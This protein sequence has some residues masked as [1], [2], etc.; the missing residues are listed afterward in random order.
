MH[1]TYIIIQSYIHYTGINTQQSV[2]VAIK[3]V[4]EHA[5]IPEN[6]NYLSILEPVFFIIFFYWDLNVTYYNYY[7]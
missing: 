4:H 3:C 7:Y 5:G 6:N 1:H 2:F